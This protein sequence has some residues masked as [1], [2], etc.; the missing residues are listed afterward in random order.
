LKKCE[1]SPIGCPDLGIKGISGG[2]RRRLSF[3]SE[4]L[5]NP[6]ILFCDEPTSGLGDDLLQKKNT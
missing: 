3:A 4:I 6:S 5:T 2:E 1:K